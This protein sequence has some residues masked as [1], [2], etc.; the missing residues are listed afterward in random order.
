MV[1]SGGERERERG[2]EGGREG[3]WRVQGR[4]MNGGEGRGTSEICYFTKQMQ[5]NKGRYR[6]KE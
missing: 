2:R 6:L 5:G 4:R 3:R 1:C